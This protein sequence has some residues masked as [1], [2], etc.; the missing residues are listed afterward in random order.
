M[1]IKKST[2]LLV[3]LGFILIIII[4]LFFIKNISAR[5]T[6]I[7]VEEINNSSKEYYLS[8][9]ASE[10]VAKDIV[11]NPKKYK[12]IVYKI[13]MK[14]KSLIMPVHFIT[15][16]PKFSQEQSKYVIGYEKGPDGVVPISISA[17]NNLIYSKS[18]IVKTN[19]LSDKELVDLAKQNEFTIE[20]V[21]GIPIP[22]IYLKLGTARFSD[23]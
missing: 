9:G 11:T 12:N 17:R 4:S 7:N 23:K 6:Q 20:G 10:Q 8:L 15:I 22:D 3:V 13:D 16:T 18:I 19:G 2:V 14:N 21:K 5:V 1:S